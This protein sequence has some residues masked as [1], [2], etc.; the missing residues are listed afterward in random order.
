MKDAASAIIS[1]TRQAAYLTFPV[2]HLPFDWEVYKAIGR[3][4]KRHPPYIYF[5]NMLYQMGIS[6]NVEILRSKI[7]VQF[8]SVKAAIEDLQWRTDPFTP[9]EKTELTD[10]LKKKFAEKKDSPV[11]T[12]E[13]Y[14][15]WA[16][17][18][19]KKEDVLQ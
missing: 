2:V 7:K 14:S 19:W 3:N 4:G 8:P 17:I 18:W 13:G 1:V 12:R 9:E 10:Y 16:L 6:A 15:K 11:F 5:Y